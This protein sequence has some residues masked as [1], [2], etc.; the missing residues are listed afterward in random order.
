[1]QLVGGVRKRFG[2]ELPLKNLFERPVL[3]DL[4]EAIDALSWLERSKAPP[5]RATEREET[6]L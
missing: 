2:V 5:A 1:M 4:A 6:L 3:A